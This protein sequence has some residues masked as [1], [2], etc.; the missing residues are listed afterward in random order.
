MVIPDGY[1]TK[2][3]FHQ[4][5]IEGFEGG[6]LILDVILQ[7]VNSRN[8][9]VFGS[10][11]N[12]AFFSLFAVSITL[13]F[14]TFFTPKKCTGT[15]DVSLR[16]NNLFPLSGNFHQLSLQLLN[17][18][19]SCQVLQLISYGPEIYPAIVLQFRNP[20]GSIERCFEGIG[21]QAAS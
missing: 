11:V 10:G 21:L 17:D 4:G 13:K 8:L 14:C 19:E 7:V 3:A 1:L 16:V 18:E 6:T 9:S 12:G 2:P 15:T 5:F 20:G